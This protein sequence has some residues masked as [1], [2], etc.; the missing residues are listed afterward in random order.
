MKFRR[1]SDKEL[2]AVEN[3]FVKF[4]SSQGFDAPEWQRVK[5]EDPDKVDFL[6]DEFST[7]FWESS[8]ERITYL[9][10]VSDM[11]RWVFQFSKSSAKVIRWVK[12]D[13]VESPELFSGVKQFP[14]EARGREIFLLLEQG[15]KPCPDER[16]KELNEL[17][18]K[19]GL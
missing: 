2:Q 9:E 15:L 8:T 5:S 19:E 18:E 1:L 11:D 13:G 12:K 4:L 14:Q 16:H 7:L 17:F 6:L 3:E 10:K